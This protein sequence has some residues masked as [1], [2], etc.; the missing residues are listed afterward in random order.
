MAD[1]RTLVVGAGA[2]ADGG[3]VGARLVES[4]ADVEFLVRG[5]RLDQL[6]SGGIRIAAA[7]GT[8]CSLAVPTVTADTLASR[9]EVVL[10]PP[11]A[12]R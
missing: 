1:M 8:T 11:R 6:R 5:G 4:G 3:Y 12:P 2:G 10:L 9:F 7:D